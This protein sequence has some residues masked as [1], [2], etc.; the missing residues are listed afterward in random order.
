MVK[1]QRATG[2]YKSNSSGVVVYCL[3]GLDSLVLWYDWMACRG[4]LVWIC[5]LTQPAVPGERQDLLPTPIFTLPWVPVQS[6]L[7]TACLFVCVWEFT[8]SSVYGATGSPWSSQGRV[9]PPL[10]H[11]LCV[12]GMVVVMGGY[13]FIALLSSL[14]LSDGE[15]SMFSLMLYTLTLS[16]KSLCIELAG[17]PC[18]FWRVPVSSWHSL[19]LKEIRVSKVWG[20]VA[21]DHYCWSIASRPAPS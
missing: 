10:P 1:Q 8:R 7:T 11:L 9:L 18:I 3:N 16:E 19:Q 17:L 12:M 5:P 21:D 6:P 13:L 14:V 2:C 20:K 15:R 4:F